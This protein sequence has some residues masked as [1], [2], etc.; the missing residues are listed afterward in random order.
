MSKNIKSKLIFGLIFAVFFGLAAG[1]ISAQADNNYAAPNVEN[2]QA[3]HYKVMDVYEVSQHG[4]AGI[5]CTICHSPVNSNHPQEV[6]PTDVSSRL[7]ATCH[8]TV[9]QEFETSVHGQKDLTCVRCHNSHTATLRADNVQTLCD[10][11][12]TDVVHDFSFSA[13]SQAD[14]LC[15]DCHQQTVDSA[16]RIGA[17]NITHTFVPN[18]E[19]CSTCH[20]QDMHNPHTD[21]C[22]AGAEADP[23]VICD[24]Q[25]V[26]QAGLTIPKDPE[27]LTEPEP[28]G[29]F[30]FIIVGVLVGMAAGMILAPWL[31]SL[32][33]KS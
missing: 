17:G 2:C 21:P 13:H 1:V 9:A 27:L 19:T 26:V 7:C 20:K 24:A 3:C 16:D 6:M 11:C 4:E 31:E 25:D 12:H 18:L 32:F 5:D 22:A 14:I 29:P 23:D 30:G 33:K 8:T 15:T 10:N 28:A